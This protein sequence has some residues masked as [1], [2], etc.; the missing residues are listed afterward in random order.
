MSTAGSHGL[1]LRWA[2]LFLA[3][4]GVMIGCES[5]PSA[6]TVRAP[7]GEIDQRAADRVT[8]VEALRDGL[9]KKHADP[10]VHVSRER[11]FAAAAELQTRAPRLD[12]A[13]FIVGL[14]QLAAMLGDAHTQV[15]LETG[16]VPCATSIPVRFVGLADGIFIDAAPEGHLDLLG[17]KVLGVGT[18]ST[19]EAAARI[20]TF[21]ACENESN[22]RETVPRWLKYNQVLH[23]LEIIPSV[24]RVTLRVDGGEGAAGVREVTIEAVGDDARVR[25]RS[26]PDASKVSLPPGRVARPEWYWHVFI[27]DGQILYCR[28]DRCADAPGKSVASWSREVMSEVE[29]KQPRKVV[30]DLR[31]NSGG[32]S[33]LLLPLVSELRSWA[34]RDRASR[35]V[36]ALIGPATF[37]S[38][39]TNALNLREFAAAV[40]VGEVPGQPIGSFGEV[41]SFTLPRSGLKVMYGSVVRDDP[42]HPV[43][44]TP[45]ISAPMRSE[46]YFAGRDPAMEAVR[47]DG[48]K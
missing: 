25:G 17:A 4:M 16:K 11:F 7:A 32:N 5:P 39:I 30:I 27:P 18:V 10:F 34:A 48:W 9:A 45:D 33:G 40:L 38:G 22:A 2:G 46:D 23:A 21:S 8:D 28:Y 15:V 43:E 1:G 6:A 14:R 26:M 36:Y 44:I 37:S 42:G 12:D 19:E 47:G 13:G 41:R 35:R 31:N 24:E 29:A 3:A 20:R